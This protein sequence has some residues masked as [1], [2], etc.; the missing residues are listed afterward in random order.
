MESTKENDQKQKKDEI[1]CE[2]C[3][4]LQ[5]EHYQEENQERNMRIVNKAEMYRTND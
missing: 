2:Y 1:D 5:Q 4:E 3:L